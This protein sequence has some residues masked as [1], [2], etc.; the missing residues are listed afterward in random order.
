[1][2][3]K[4]HRSHADAETPAELL[5]LFHTRN[6][7]QI[8]G[9]ELLAVALGLCSFVDRLRGKCVRVWCDNKGGECCL[10]KG[11]AKTGDHNLLIHTVWLLAAKEGFGLWMERVQQR[12]LISLMK[13]G[14]NVK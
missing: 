8:M 10:R 11:S 9:Q 3:D 1:V 4:E 5:A 6:D 14:A 13:Q 7:A 2:T 12:C